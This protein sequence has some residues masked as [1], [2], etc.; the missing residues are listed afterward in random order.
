MITE[1]KTRQV[2]PD[3]TVFAIS[4][5]LNLGNSLISIENA[6]RRLIDEGARKL[7]VDLAGLN[8]ID[9]S[10]VGMLV[11]LCGHTEQKGGRLRVAGAQGGVAK[12]LETVHLNRLA[13][14]DAD[15]ES[16]CRHLAAEGASA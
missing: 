9:S 3:V 10:G 14:M 2:E 7:V 15:V 4:G 13:P 6:I 12:V 11:T 5:R 8:A 1:T 16:A